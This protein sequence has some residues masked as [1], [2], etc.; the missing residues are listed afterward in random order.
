MLFPFLW[1]NSQI[2]EKKT[3]ILHRPNLK[4]SRYQSVLVNLN[5]TCVCANES[6]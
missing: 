3:I 5:A 6:Y 2:G 4:R 1:N